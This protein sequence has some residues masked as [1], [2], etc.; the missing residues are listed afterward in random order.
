M[1]A[2]HEGSDDI[3][4]GAFGAAVVVKRVGFEEEVEKDLEVGRKE[5]CVISSAEEGSCDRRHIQSAWTWCCR[6]DSS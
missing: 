5:R 4:N 6:P 3:V 2:A 1:L